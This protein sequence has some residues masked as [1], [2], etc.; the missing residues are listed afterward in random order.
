MSYI[1]ETVSVCK[2]SL[3]MLRKLSLFFAILLLLFAAALPVVHLAKAQRDV[4]GH[5][6]RLHI[7]A[8][9]DE[10]ADQLL[11]QKVRDRILKEY[12]PVFDACGGAADAADA[13]AALSFRIAR[14]AQ[15]ELRRNGALYP[16]S[17]RV[18]A[19]DFPTKRYGA[20]RLPAGRYT[21]LNVRIGSAKGHNWW[22]VL[23]PPLCLTDGTVEADEET[24]NTLKK[25]LSAEEYALLTNTEDIRVTVKFRILEILGRYF[26]S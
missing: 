23:Y 5:V 21:A 4:A 9:S 26:R 2:K 1:D 18:E 19:A 25:E 3:K 10:D 12:A 15:Q 11:K 20:V 14:T 17:V 13:A 8:N 6:L 16:V 24:L 7:L 22:C